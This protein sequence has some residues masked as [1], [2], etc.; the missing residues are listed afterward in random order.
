[1]RIISCASYYGSGSSAITDLLAEYDSCASLADYE[2]R[3]MQD[4][5]GI[6]DL[7]FALVE[8]HH[9]HN[10]GHALKKYKQIVEFLGNPRL[11]KYEHYFNN[12]WKSISNDYINELT[13]FT[14]TGY[15]HQDVIDK[16]RWFHF[17]KRAV[18][19]LLKKTIWRNQPDRSLNELPHEITYCSYPTEKKFLLATKKY[20]ER[21]FDV[22][23]TQK[24]KNIMVD[25][26]VPAT[27][28]NRYIRY[29]NDIKVFVVDRDPRDIYLL[30]KY[31]WKGRVI[32]TESV[33]KYCQ[34]FEFTRRHR[35]SE[36]YNSD[37]IMY[38]Q[39]EDLV[40]KYEEMVVKI[41]NWLGLTSEEHDNPRTSFD[42]GISIKNTKLWER[43]KGVEEEVAF[44]EKALPNYLYKY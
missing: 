43:L 10:S 4:P 8:N 39:F 36:N 23:N 21:L 2:F 34:W 26:I 41:E 14:Y 20:I 11:K 5:G 33:D 16:G 18:N 30:E 38:V 19:K 13:E 44:I 22:A 1:M 35:K 15:W 6:A 40:Y 3:F 27:N 12:Q 32:P 29:F 37:N 25:Q 28:L 9:R 24:K 31:I 7:E 42:P 17:R